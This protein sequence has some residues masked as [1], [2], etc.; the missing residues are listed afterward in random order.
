MV[1]RTSATSPACGSRL[2]L[3][4]TALAALSTLASPAPSTEAALA[5]GTSRPSLTERHP[6]R[7]R[8]LPVFEELLGNREDLKVAVDRRLDFF[9]VGV[10]RRRPL[11]RDA[12]DIVGLR[13]EAHQDIHVALGAEILA[14]DRTEQG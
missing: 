6:E 7:H 9:L 2:C 8:Q 10:Q 4:P 11:G 3:L 14:Q 1:F 12:K 5:A 13:I